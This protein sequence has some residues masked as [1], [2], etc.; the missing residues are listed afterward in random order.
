[1][2]GDES[3]NNCDVTV[4]LDIENTLVRFL[5][6]QEVKDYVGGAV[7]KYT[8]ATQGSTNFYWGN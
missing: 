4:E 5:L 7:F 6:P 1:M 2:Y 8:I 3:L